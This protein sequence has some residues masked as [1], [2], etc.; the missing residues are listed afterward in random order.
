MRLA[1][2]DGEGGGGGGWVLLQP[3]KSASEVVCVRVCVPL[4][5]YSVLECAALRFPRFCGRGRVGS[6]CL[7]LTITCKIVEA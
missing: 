4:V 1:E 5:G 7:F 2:R 6:L 3:S